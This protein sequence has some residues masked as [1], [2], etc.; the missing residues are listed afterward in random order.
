M[1]TRSTWTTGIRR[2][3]LLSA[4]GA[5]FG[6]LA[7]FVAQVGNPAVAC[8]VYYACA[9]ANLQAECSNSCCKGGSYST[10]TWSSGTC[11]GSGSC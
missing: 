2:Q 5:V 7:P 11:S 1:K 8:N 9:P 6:T 3:L 10:C 4:V